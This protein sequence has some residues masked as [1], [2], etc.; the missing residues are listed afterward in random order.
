MS[1]GSGATLPEGL[2]DNLKALDRYI[3]E[4]SGVA[5]E[6]KIP[7]RIYADLAKHMANAVRNTKNAAQGMA[8]ELARVRG[9]RD[10]LLSLVNT[11]E[12]ELWNR[13][14]LH[15]VLALLRKVVRTIDGWD[16]PMAHPFAKFVTPAVR[17]AVGAAIKADAGGGE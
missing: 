5:I 3:D 4:W 7:A 17:A 13:T 1:A 15:D 2:A 16:G 10:K 8:D 6:Y 11:P 9:E 12:P 14:V